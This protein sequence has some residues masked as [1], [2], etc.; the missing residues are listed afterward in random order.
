MKL[1]P[2]IRIVVTEKDLREQIRTLCDLYGWKAMQIIRVVALVL[3]CPEPYCK[4]GGLI[5]DFP[6][7]VVHPWIM[8]RYDQMTCFV[9]QLFYRIF[10]T[11]SYLLVGWPQGQSYRL[12]FLSSLHSES[13]HRDGI[14]RDWLYIV[15]AVLHASYLCCGHGK[16]AVEPFFA[17]SR[18]IYATKEDELLATGDYAHALLH[19]GFLYNAWQSLFA[20]GS[21]LWA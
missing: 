8:A 2:S 7:N 6:E 13:W 16:H 17:E 11:Y 3:Y 20:S 21:L 15:L 10:H 14:Y 12:R 4:V 5:L 9:S 1:K 18:Y 19:D